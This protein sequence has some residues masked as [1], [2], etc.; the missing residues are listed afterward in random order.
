[1]SSGKQGELL[2]AEWIPPIMFSV[3]VMVAMYAVKILTTLHY[4][5]TEAYTQLTLFPFYIVLAY[6]F[7][8]GA[9]LICIMRAV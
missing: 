1:M 3:V 4:S 5:R 8:E 6:L 2:V 9:E 7:F